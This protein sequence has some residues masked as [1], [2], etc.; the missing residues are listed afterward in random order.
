MKTAYITH[1]DCTLHEMGSW[2]PERPDRLKAIN[3]HLAKTGLLDIL[4]Q[5]TAEPATR[6]QLERAHSPKYLDYLQSLHPQQGYVQAD[7]DTI[8]CPHSL[9]AAELAAGAVVQAVDGVLAGDF[10]RAFCAG[11]PPGH[12]AERAQAMGFCLYNNIAVGVRHAMVAHG[13]TRV[14]VLDFDIHHGNGT[15]DI[16]KDDP[17]VLVCSSFQHPFYPGRYA[18]LELPNIVNTKLSAG[19]GS[20]QFRALIGEDWW[21]ALKA[22]QPQLIFVSAGFD[23][24][25]DDP[26]SEVNLREEDF[27]WI[28][29]L[30][31]E[32][33]NQFAQGRV[34]STLEGG[35]DLVALAR[36]VYAHITHLNKNYYKAD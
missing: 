5:I 32:T 6:E 23:G 29:D 12:H 22:H 33:A 30:I 34:I 24:H 9:R 18:D 35:Y 15:V 14:A 31:T 10:Q 26:L 11:R 7:G 21:P 13:V 27:V 28:T 16:F 20:E 1:N 17:A 2:H 4:L 19:D 8:I 36:S 25:Q 3:L